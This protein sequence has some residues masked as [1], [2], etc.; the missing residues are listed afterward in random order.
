MGYATEVAH[1]GPDALRLAAAFH[2][3]I[4]LLDIGL[5]V[6][7]GY[8]L[9]AHLREMPGLATIGLVAVTGYGQASDRQRAKEAGFQHHL[10][11]PIN[12]DEL[13]GVLAKRAAAAAGDAATAS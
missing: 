6:M 13:E 3:Q 4:A 11:K 9:A 1:D 12:L 10:V 7:D 8:E 5:P 2:P